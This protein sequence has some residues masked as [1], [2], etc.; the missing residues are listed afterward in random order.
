MAFLEITQMI[1][2][3]QEVLKRTLSTPE[4]RYSV[5]PNPDLASHIL[6][7]SALDHFCSLEQQAWSL[8]IQSILR[9]NT[10]CHSASTSS[11][12]R[13]GG[14]TFACTA[15]SQSVSRRRCPTV[16]SRRKAICG[17]TCCMVHAASTALRE[18]KCSRFMFMQLVS[19]AR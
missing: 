3:T 17:K 6:V 10:A 2:S 4:R 1:Q 16:T 9:S 5:P 18:L 13:I 11:R 15:H 7:G 14:L 12:G 8:T 19:L